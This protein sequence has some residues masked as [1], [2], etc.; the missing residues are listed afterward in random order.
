MKKSLLLSCL[1]LVSQIVYAQCGAL[2]GQFV[3]T[4]QDDL[5]ELSSCEVFNGDLVIS[6]DN[7]T[8]VTAL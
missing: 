8:N 5:D 1:I 4:S 7:I 6:S 2:G 3:I